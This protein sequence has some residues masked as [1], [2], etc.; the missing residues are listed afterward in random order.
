MQSTT[1]FDST[2]T[3]KISDSSNSKLSTMIPSNPAARVTNSKIPNRF[4]N[5]R[6]CWCSYRRSETKRVKN[7]CRPP[8][9]INELAI[10]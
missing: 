8:V 9:R 1:K 3:R 5:I 2:S 7:S 6:S 10:R 4:G